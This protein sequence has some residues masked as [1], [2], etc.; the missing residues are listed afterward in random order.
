MKLDYSAI[1]QKKNHH[2]KAK[3]RSC[4]EEEQMWVQRIQGKGYGM[5]GIVEK[6]SD[7]FYLVEVDGKVCRKHADQLRIKSTNG[8]D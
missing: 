8:A 5:G 6:L 2:H 1:K 7:Y 3:P 4:E